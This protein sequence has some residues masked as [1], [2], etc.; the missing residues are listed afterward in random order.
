MVRPGP[1]FGQHLLT[2]RLFRKIFHEEE[3]TRRNVI[4]AE[5]ETVSAA[6]V[7]KSF[8]R[9]QFLKSLDRFYKAI[10]NAAETIDDFADKQHFLSSAARSRRASSMASNSSSGGV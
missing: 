5:V 3:F 7:S 4:A 1:E 10:E 8:S 9:D 6:L 2:E